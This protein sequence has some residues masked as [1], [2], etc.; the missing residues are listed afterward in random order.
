MS[1]TIRIVVIAL[2]ASSAFAA[3][4]LADEKANSIEG[5][6]S[7]VEQK[8]GPSQEYRKLPDGTVMTE[9]IV[10]GRFY[11]TV[12]KNGKVV[13]AAGGRYKADNDKF[14]EIIEYV[15]GEGV[16][17]SFVG[18]SFEFTITVKGE[19]MTKVGTIQVN[20]QDSRIDEKWERLQTVSERKL[21]IRPTDREVGRRYGA[22]VDSSTF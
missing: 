18:S 15:S 3:S 20:G 11:W 17:E 9:Y 5:A 14:T 1:H 16:P 4:N 21:W 7:Q 8:N 2:V 13:A 12:V 10:G 22:V 6:W 19:R